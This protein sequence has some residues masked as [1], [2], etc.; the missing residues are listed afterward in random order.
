MSDLQQATDDLKM[1]AL[2][3]ADLGKL[4]NLPPAYD[5]QFRGRMQVR[6]LFSILDSLAFFLKSRALE[7]CKNPSEAFSKNELEV[8]REGVF[9]TKPD[10]TEFLQPSFP[11]PERNIRTSFRCY[12]KLSGGP[13]PL[14]SQTPLPAHFA[15]IIALR[16]RLTHPK[17]LADLAITEEEFSWLTDAAK[18]LRDSADWVFEREKEFIYARNLALKEVVDKALAALRAPVRG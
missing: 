4:A 8:L 3:V 10:G 6:T 9:R 17:K 13:S 16:N 7:R 18:W 14:E 2:L 12:S 11:D 15:Y 5:Q 1:L